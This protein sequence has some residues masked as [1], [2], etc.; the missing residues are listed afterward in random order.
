MALHSASLAFS[1]DGRS[2][3]AVEREGIT[4][5]D[6]QTGASCRVSVADPIA[7]I[8]FDEQMWVA[9]GGE[10]VLAR[11]G[12][13]GA[14]IGATV[15]LPDGGSLVA[16]AVGAPAALWTSAPGVV[17]IEEPGGLT[18]SPT[19]RGELAVPLTGRRWVTAT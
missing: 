7:A 11:Y 13:D 2:L 15:S 17:V 6:T 9:H 10:P 18:S 1:R 8:G 16:A 19:P 12:R 14:R 3:I 4:L 5:A